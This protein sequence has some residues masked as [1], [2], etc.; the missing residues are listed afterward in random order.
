MH[1]VSYLSVALTAVGLTV[2][3]PQ[4]SV[5]KRSPEPTFEDGKYLI[6]RATSFSKKATY[7]F[8]GSS[9][10]QGLSASNYNAGSTHKFTPSNVKV[11]NGYLELL[12]NGGQTAMPYKSAEVVTDIENIKY[13]SVRTVAIL[14][15]PA[16]VCNGKFIW[17]CKQIELT[18]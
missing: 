9:L 8:T 15:E 6:D 13:A 17:T 5:M 2:A 1:L 4:P 11:R 16:G 7:T 10:P 18:F 3:A 14:S 12:V